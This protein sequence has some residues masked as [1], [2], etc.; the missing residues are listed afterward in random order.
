MPD[1][2][3]RP[4]TPEDKQWIE[5]FIIEQWGASSV[6]GHGVVYYPHDLA[7]FVAIQNALPVGLVTFHIL[8]EACEIVTIDCVQPGI[9]VGTALIE[10][11]KEVSQKAGCTRL[12]LVTT[13]DNLHAL[14]FYQK[15]GFVLV[16]I[17]RNA[18]EK[19]RLLKPSIPLFG[20]ASIP[21]RDE[22]ELEMQL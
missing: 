11:V 1:F 14:G 10:S 2:T 15:R 21:I 8:G 5:P 20:F 7:G 9:G 6:V 3:I 12:W 19:S 16:K 17:H 4:T 18:V 22:I 13:N